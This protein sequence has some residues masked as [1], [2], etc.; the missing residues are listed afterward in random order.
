MEKDEVQH[1]TITV[2][3]LG[4]YHNLQ[5]SLSIFILLCVLTQ[6][7]FLLVFAA[8]FFLFTLQKGN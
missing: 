2:I 4:L 7:D 8:V 6:L 1:S 5:F 3:I